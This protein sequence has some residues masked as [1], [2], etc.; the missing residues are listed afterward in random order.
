M[1]SRIICFI[2]FFFQCNLLFAATLSPLELKL[3]EYIDAHTDEQLVLLEKLV[4]VNSGTA[5]IKGVKTV[6]EILRPFFVKLGFKTEWRYEPQSLQRAPTLIA[7]RE[8]TNGKRILIIAHLDTVFA[9]NS[10]FQRFQ[11]KNNKAKGPGVL[12][13][14]GGIV[15]LL[16]ALKAL[17]KEK[18]LE[19]TTITIALMGDEEDS[20]KPTSISRKPLVD[21]AKESDVA[22]DFEPAVTLETATIARRGVSHWSIETQ[23]YE[24]HSSAIFHKDVGAG[25]IFELARILNAMRE[26][27]QIEQ[28]L[29]FNPGL[30]LG[31]TKI[32]Y[33]KI[34]SEGTVFGKQNVVAKKALA[35]GDFRFLT[36]ARRQ[37]FEKNLNDIIKNHLP[38]TK[39]VVTF[40]SGIPPMPPTKNNLILLEKYSKVSVDLD[41]GVIKP[42]PASLRGAGD[43]SHIAHIVPANLS[44][45]GVMGIGAHS[46]IETIDLS[47]LPIQTKRA[48][49]F[50]Y[51][52]THD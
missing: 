10:P 34:T 38:N 39:A 33:N 15:V 37:Y 42:L 18:A 14:K 3:K 9:K 36:D 2:F 20:G 21:A 24:A 19:N 8:G 22:I 51:R 5:N 6:G 49:V 41:L 28:D 26:K 30:V 7:K 43:I 35:T 32:E 11:R 25:A 47:S 50:I 12:D 31:G 13:D 16:Y 52:L 45:L 1:I 44:G 27:L 17:D 46:V 29:T 4:N 23:G 40:E 48:A